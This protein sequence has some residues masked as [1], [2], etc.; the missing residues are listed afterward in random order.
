MRITT[1]SSIPQYTIALIAALL[2][3]LAFAVRAD[4]SAV[5][6]WTDETGIVHYSQ[7]PPEHPEVSVE[8]RRIELS[9]APDYDPCDDP[10]SVHNQAER[11]G[12]TWDSILEE[13]EAEATARRLARAQE[14][15]AELERE[16]NRLAAARPVYTSPFLFAR[17][18]PR[19]RPLAPGG[20][21]ER[22]SP[23]MSA[24][25]M[26]PACRGIRSSPM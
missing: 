26:M 14:R 22:K 13:K 8:K 15:L 17:P 25:S 20:F 24:G 23:S 21:H 5:Y 11:I 9:N 3:A 12:E 7:W 2:Q 4:T 19:V 6:R 1:H 16:T 18:H 10:Y